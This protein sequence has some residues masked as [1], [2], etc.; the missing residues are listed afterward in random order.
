M[1]YPKPDITVGAALYALV[2]EA[3]PELTKVSPVVAEA[4]TKFPFA[5]YRRTG[6]TLADS[7]DRAAGLMRICYTVSVLSDRYDAALHLA[8]KL[9]KGVVGKTASAA[10][11]AIND[12]ALTDADEDYSDGTYSQNLTFNLTYSHGTSN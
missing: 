3:V 8:Q 6:F 1:S 5:V 2:R 11:F 10:G 9:I 4:D 7:K 12:V